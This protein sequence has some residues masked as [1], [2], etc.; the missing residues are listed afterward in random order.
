MNFVQRPAALH[1]DHGIASN[2][3]DCESRRRLSSPETGIRIKQ[4][5]TLLRGSISSTCCDAI[6]MG[7]CITCSISCLSSYMAQFV[8]NSSL[9][10][11]GCWIAC[12]TS[13]LPSH[14]AQLRSN[15]AEVTEHFLQHAN[16]RITSGCMWDGGRHYYMAPPFAGWQP[17]HAAYQSQ[18]CCQSAAFRR[19]SKGGSSAQAPHQCPRCLQG[20]PPYTE[21]G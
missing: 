19:S 13:S 5:P 15:R 3:G 16:S 4:D 10:Q 7:C 6:H 12:N 18:H 11:M 21:G 17:R 2:A 14:M 8:R 20:R 1:R 9:Q